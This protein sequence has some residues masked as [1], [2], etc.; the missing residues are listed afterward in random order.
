MEAEPGRFGKLNT[1][2]GIKVTELITEIDSPVYQAAVKADNDSGGQDSGKQPFSD[3]RSFQISPLIYDLD[4]LGD[5]C[6]ASLSCSD[7]SV[8]GT[9]AFIDEEPGPDGR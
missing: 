8:T 6:K 4:S 9:G 7:N 2:I 3:C 1:E 5:G